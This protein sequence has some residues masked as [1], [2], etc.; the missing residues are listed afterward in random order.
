LELIAIAFI[1]WRFMKS[2]LTKTVLQVIVGGGIVFA[3]GWWL[4]MLG[5]R[6]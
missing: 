2:S 6:E 4:G 5:A 1:R 3:I